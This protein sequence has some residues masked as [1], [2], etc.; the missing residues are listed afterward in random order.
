MTD[1]VV[2]V[3]DEVKI[4]ELLRDYCEQAGYSTLLFHD[5]DDAHAWLQHHPARMVLLDLMLPGTDGLTICQSLRKHSDIPVIMITAQVEEIDRLLGLGLGADDYI[6]KPFSPREVIARMKVILRRVE[7]GIHQVSQLGIDEPET[8]GLNL[9]EDSLEVSFADKTVELT[10]VEFKLFKTLFD[11]PGRIYSR[12]HLMSHIYVD[13][14]IV[15]DRTIDSHIKK[16][17]KKLMGLGIPEDPVCSVYGV[18]YK[19]D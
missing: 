6:C 1:P 16:L 10:A 11:S 13:N 19:Y 4:A 9:N 15:S 8:P 17:R 12:D 5:G 7:K 14:R 18:G 2:I 3:E